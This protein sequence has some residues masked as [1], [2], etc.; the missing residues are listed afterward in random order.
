M[1]I[2]DYRY[3]D[4]RMKCK[5]S[6]TIYEGTCIDV[7]PAEDLEA[8]EDAIDLEMPSG[9]ILCI[10]ESQIEWIEEVKSW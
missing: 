8:E 3:K 4:I 9:D 5:I 7:S 10:F 1:N 2:W 6:E